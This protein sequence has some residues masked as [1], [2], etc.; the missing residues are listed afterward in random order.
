MVQNMEKESLIPYRPL[1]GNIRPGPCKDK[2][3]CLEKVI[4]MGPVACNGKTVCG[5]PTNI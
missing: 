3:I 4:N 2:G 5:T 1:G